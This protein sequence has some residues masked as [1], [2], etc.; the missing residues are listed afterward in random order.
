MWV[1]SDYLYVKKDFIPVFSAEADREQPTT[2][3]YF[4]PHKGMKE[5]LYGL[6]KALE[7]D[8]PSD[9]RSLWI[10][11]AYGT[12]KTFAAFVIKH[13]LE[14]DLNEIEDYFKKHPKLEELWS[15]L[16]TLRQSGNY[17]VVY[18]S[19]SSHITSPLKLLV[20]M[21]QVIKQ[22]LKEKGYVDAPGE[23]LFENIWD[24][25]TNPDSS[26]DW[27]KA[28]AKH[29]SK[30]MDFSAPEKVIEKLKSG[31]V[32]LTGRVAR[33]LEEEGFQVNDNPQ[34]VKSWLKGIINQNKLKGIVFIWDEFTDFFVNNVPTTSLQ[35]LAQ[36]TAE[37]PFYFF[38]V[39]HRS[40]ESFKRIDE[41]TKKKILERFHNFKFEMG[42]VTAY[43]LIAN[44]I[45][46]KSDVASQWSDKKAR[47]WDRISKVTRHLL[48]IGSEVTQEDFKGLIPIHPYA[49]FLLASISKQ[50]SSS[51]RTL[52][53]FLKEDEQ[54]SFTQFLRYYPSNEWY[55]FTADS[56]WDYFFMDD[57]SELAERVRDVVS[58]CHSREDNIGEEEQKRL[59]KAI[60]LLIALW[61]QMPGE[62]LVRPTRS[63]LEL[64]FAGTPV[65]EKIKNI[66]RELSDKGFI[67]T[68]PMGADEEY[69]VPLA[70]IDDRKIEEKR[71][72]I[73]SIYPFDKIIGT[74]EEIGKK[75]T[76]I[77]EGSGSVG[78]RQKINIVSARDF[79]NK[80]ERVEPTLE[81]FEIG[82]VFVVAR[83]EEELAAAEELAAKLSPKATRTAYIVIQS[84]FGRKRWADLVNHKAHYRYCQEIRDVENAK[85]Y[86]KRVE[87]VVEEWLAS[88]R[89]GRKKVHICGEEMEIID[90]SG[91]EMFL[92]QTIKRFYPY[93]P[94]QISNKATL[95]AGTHAGKA[96]AEIGLGIKNNIMQPFTDLVNELKKQGFW[97]SI[98]AFRKMPDH[99]LSRMKQEIDLFFANN[100]NI[101]LCEIWDRLQEAPYG[102]MPSP[103]GV[104]LMGYLLRDY[105]QG[106]YYKDGPDNCFSLN[107]NKLAELIEG[108]IKKN[109]K[110]YE[111][112]CIC[113]MSAEDESFCQLVQ[114][115]F[116]LPPDKTSYP[117]EARKALRNYFTSLG[118][119][120]WALSYAIDKNNQ[121]YDT[122]NSVM[123]KLWE[124]LKT[125]D[126]VSNNFSSAN[127]KETLA[128][129]QRA[130]EILK[131]LVKKE[132][133][134]EGMKNFIEQKQP[135]LLEIMGQLNLDL[136]YIMDS[137]KQM[138][139]EEVWLWEQAK[140]ETRLPEIY[141]DFNLTDAL[142]QLCGLSTRNVKDAID[143]FYNQWLKKAGK[144]P[145]IVL[146]ETEDEKAGHIINQLIELI[147]QGTKIYNQKLELAE[148][149]KKYK[150]QIRQAIYD[151]RATLVRWSKKHHDFTMTY[152]EAGEILSGL[153]DLVHQDKLV[154]IKNAIEYQIKNINKRKLI[155]EVKNKWQEITQSDSP[156]AWSKENKIP[157]QW[158]LEGQDYVFVYE[159]LNRP[160]GKTE[161]ELQK[162]LR[163][164]HENIESFKKL[165]DGD[166]INKRF[167]T[168]AAPAYKRLLRKEKDIQSLKDFLFREMKSEVYHWPNMPDKVNS[169]VKNWIDNHY[170]SHAYTE[171]LQTVEK[172][173]EHQVKNLLKQLAADPL[174]GNLLLEGED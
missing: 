13:L 47:L 38:L 66:T 117:E 57:N 156:L 160:E 42:P 2:W 59:F 155:R 150:Q 36:S 98:D 158:A 108:V 168:I 118:Y 19:S 135:A 100:E 17:L 3:K 18:H 53:K 94:E 24:K 40:P 80:R 37:I 153:P 1:Y 161:G 131:S 121:A 91:Y 73:E 67:H 119:P 63:I 113:K 48:D 4:I 55:W 14:D 151:Q 7:R 78:R 96:A 128:V 54:F 167:I 72:E 86:Q 133:F 115:I 126:D 39:T 123:D 143:N 101:Y 81:P 35:E 65:L 144:L 61:R 74:T 124:I 159:L 110:G 6:I 165:N 127:I 114:E 87:S 129:L 141:A 33:V 170:Q 106:Y 49:A 154:E 139:S 51:Q 30:F 107:H 41:D 132:K 9:K 11:G 104:T 20:E 145:L 16:K 89:Q 157:I 82:L 105:G 122:L 90:Q 64:M 102:L 26:F 163:I 152:S 60:M 148:D 92:L 27:N 171:V 56:L 136:D 5:I 166:A 50:F 71:K 45:E 25:L 93:G 120:I 99:P 146:A 22:N 62:R 10:N 12:G 68:V 75:L 88:V 116:N 70:T 29:Q 138:M 174:V 103:I 109:K 69:T 84:P 142:N 15:R 76:K 173:P 95:Y 172:M 130:R 164:L 169:L 44:A 58:Y 79:K 137:I 147:H 77:F 23:T 34:A 28:F 125:P 21:Q 46:V 112:F 83:E 149:L 134:A 85:F 32:D 97:E 8:K 52:F 140:V 162:V 31:N 43:Q 111:D